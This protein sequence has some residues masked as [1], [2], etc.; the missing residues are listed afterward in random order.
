[1]TTV[2][3]LGRPNVGKSSLLNRLVGRYVALVGDEPGVTRDP[4]EVC[5]EF[6]PGRP[7]TLV[8][9]GGLDAE[10]DDRLAATIGERS[11]AVAHAADV[12]LLVLDATTGPV[13]R[14]RELLGRLRRLGCRPV[15][16]VNKSEGRD[17]VL[18]EAEFSELGLDRLFVVSARRG[19]GLGPLRDFLTT[20]SG[21]A[22]DS[23]PSAATKVVLLGRPNA[24][25]STL[26]NRMAGWERV[27]SDPVPGTT[28]DVIEVPVRRE[29]ESWVM[30]DTAGIRRRR[31]VG[32][33]LEREAVRRGL[34]VLSTADLAL[35][36]IDAQAGIHA[37]DV[38]LAA[39]IARRGCPRV[40]AL[41]KWDG[42]EDP[43]RGRL[44][45]EARARFSFLGRVPLV[46]VSA[47]TGSGIRELFS[48]L[49]AARDEVAGLVLSTSSLNRVLNEALRLQPLPRG[50]HGE[51]IHL[52]YAHPGGR[53]PPR[54][55]VHG[56]MT[57]YVP[58]SFRR[59][60]A[61]R[62]ALSIGLETQGLVVDFRDGSTRER[63]SRPLRD[64]ESR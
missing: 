2:A 62:F 36:V 48:A 63:T 50:P 42:L 52:R 29:A 21:T 38:S 61:H 56:D 35:L 14:D 41:N 58:E 57:R 43:R 25:K 6:V 31:S 8:D 60:L 17:P 18:V 1:M 23:E 7:L 54:V 46:S 15:G 51:C 10:D 22:A 53:H 5:V 55:I 33:G 30:V 19:S 20:C 32:D 4:V 40:I 12:L 47:A 27:L 13:P 59:F 45:D 3:L 11:L 28:R 49:R 26:V 37:Q 24:G 64:R 9:T 34:D 16:V 44:L 39:V